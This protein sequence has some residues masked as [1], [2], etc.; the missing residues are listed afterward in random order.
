MLNTGIREGERPRLKWKHIDFESKRILIHSSK[1]KMY[2]VI[3]MSKSVEKVLKGLEKKTDYVFVNRDGSP[4]LKIRKSLS[5]ACREAGLKNVTPH[6]LRHTFASHLVMS[7]VDLNTV[8]TLL[9]HPDISTT[10][11]YSH[12]TEDHL[13]RSVE[14]LPWDS[15]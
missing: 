7:G 4:Q 10:M 3:P 12:L 8:K 14:K 13:A 2:R 11:I 9:G 5:T 15:R 1:V 6:T